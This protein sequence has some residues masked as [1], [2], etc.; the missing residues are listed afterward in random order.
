MSLPRANNADELLGIEDRPTRE[1]DVP[2]WGFSVLIR[3]PDAKTSILISNSTEGDIAE[4]VARTIMAGV[5]EPALQPH[6]IERLK[7]KSSG[8]LMRLYSAILGK[9]KEA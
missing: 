7:E 9:K 3:E 5:I 1:I 8:V 4:R 6:H 2:E